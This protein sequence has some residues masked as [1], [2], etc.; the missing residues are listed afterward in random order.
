[1]FAY[2]GLWLA[3]YCILSAQHNYRHREG[4]QEEHTMCSF[5]EEWFYSLRERRQCGLQVRETW[6]GAGFPFWPINVGV[7]IT[8][9]YS[10]HQTKFHANNVYWAST[11]VLFQLTHKDGHGYDKEQYLPGN[12]LGWNILGKNA[13]ECKDT[14]HSKHRIQEMVRGIKRTKEG[15]RG[16][17]V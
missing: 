17:T 8:T 6:E 5:G 14:R 16:L 10:P 4:T 7:I 1:M 13:K 9:S 3:P 2:R 15:G 12:W 11:T